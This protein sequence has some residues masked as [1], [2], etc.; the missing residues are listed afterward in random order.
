MEEMYG[1]CNRE[2]GLEEERVRRIQRAAAALQ[3]R[4]LAW[5]SRVMALLPKG[6]PLTSDDTEQLKLFLA[7]QRRHQLG[8]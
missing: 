3:E 7:Q 4:V 1:L 2:L 8:T 5:A 6:L